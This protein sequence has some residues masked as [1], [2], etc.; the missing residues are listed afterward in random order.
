[1]IRLETVSGTVRPGFEAVRDAFAANFERGLEVGAAC[2]VYHQGENVVDLWGGARDRATGDPWEA[3]TMACVASATK[4]PAGMAM[5]L[6]HS[7]GLF[8]YDERVATY[9]PEFAQ[10]GKENITIRQLLS[11]QAGLFALD[12]HVDVET[13]RDLDKLAVILARQRPRWEPGA[14]QAYHAITL[15]FY[16]S[17]LLRRVDPTHRSLGRFFHEEIAIPLGLDFYIGLPEE[18]P[19]S[20]L[21][22]IHMGAPGRDM[23]K[24]PA[25]LVFGI[26]YPRSRLHRA[27]WGDLPVDRE[28]GYPR[29]VEVPSGGGIGTARA[30]AKAYGVFATGGRELGLRNE[31]LDRLMAPAVPPRRG[32]YDEVLKV[33]RMQLS[34]GFM[35]P[36]PEAPFGHPSSFGMPGFGG[37]LGFADPHAGI[38]FAYLT[39]RAGLSLADPRQQALRAAMYRAIGER[40]PRIVGEN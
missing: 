20:R 7:R 25:G 13:E 36:S 18:I 26:M 2:A 21:A 39:N 9:W 4:G 11:H 22:R 31:T 30:L 19:N 23:F 40:N 38:G 28:R 27:L 10:H 1:M 24:A 37:F 33:E 35:K 17:E 8:G 32:F 15:G 5:A 34:L 6:A 12:E 14:R 3:D 16:E 29:N